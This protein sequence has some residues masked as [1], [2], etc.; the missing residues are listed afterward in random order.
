MEVDLNRNFPAFFH[1]NS[2]IIDWSVIES[3]AIRHWMENNTFIL[4]AALHGGALVA[5]Y[6][7]DIK[8]EISKFYFMDF[9]KFL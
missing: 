9:L 7:F 4:S 2:R 6:P 8:E 3:N 1:N 5:N